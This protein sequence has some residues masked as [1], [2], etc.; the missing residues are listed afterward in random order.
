MLLGHKLNVKKTILQISLGG[1]VSVNIDNVF[2]V[3]M[4]KS[5]CKEEKN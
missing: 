4:L 3:T 2:N 1:K 5:Q